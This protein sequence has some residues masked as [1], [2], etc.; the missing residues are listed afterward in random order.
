[1]QGVPVEGEVV[2]LREVRWNSFQPNF[3]V[4]FQ[5]G[6]LEDAPAVYLAS[7][8]QLPAEQRDALQASLQVAFPNVSSIDVT[9]AVQRM[10][11]LIDQ[12]QWA[13][14]GS[15]GRGAAVSIDTSKA[16]AHKGVVALLPGEKLN[17]ELAKTHRM[18]TALVRERFLRTKLIQEDA[19]TGGYAPLVIQDW[20][21][22]WRNNHR[23]IIEDAAKAGASKSG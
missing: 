9:R 6:V 3:F 17:S 12:L 13:L 4:V 2:S 15:A 1:M 18:F 5:P 7:V 22:L 16:T 19:F 23:T 10:L 11:G 14:A 8:P 20:L 21:A